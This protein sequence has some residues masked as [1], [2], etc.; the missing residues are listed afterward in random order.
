MYIYTYTYVYIQGGFPDSSAGKES[1]CNAG[2]SGSIPGLGRSP[3]EGTDY[4]L[5]CSWAPLVSQLVRKLPAMRETWVQ[6]LGWEDPLEKWERLPTPG[7]WPGEFHG[8]YSPRGH[9]ESH[10]T[11]QISLLFCITEKKKNR[12]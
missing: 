8:L 12:Q 5:Q 11:E 4:P 6:S 2:D 7:F 1:A 3:G 9:K 10:T